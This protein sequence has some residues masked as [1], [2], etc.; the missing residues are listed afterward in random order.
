MYN[1]N[2]SPDRKGCLQ[3]TAAIYAR[4]LSVSEPWIAGF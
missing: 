3:A 2:V 1:I 4:R